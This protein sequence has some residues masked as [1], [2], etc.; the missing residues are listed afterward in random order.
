MTWDVLRADLRP[1]PPQ[2]ALAVAIMAGVGLLTGLISSLPSPLPEMRLDDGQILLNT[3]KI[4]L[5]AGIAFGA[6]V[7]LMLWLWVTRDLAKCLLAMAIVLIGWLVAV[8]TANDVFE[9]VIGSSLFGT[10]QGAKASREITGVLL[11]GV[12]GGAVGAGLT[13]FGAGIAAE[14]IRRAKNWVLI[15]AVGAALGVLLFPAIDLGLLPVLFV[16]WQALV[17]AAIAFGLIRT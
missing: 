9:A 4:P 14:P 11:G 3:E 1:R 17:A 7:G 6:G 12:S 8:N 2:G 15:V 16:P 5:H 10:A 13:A